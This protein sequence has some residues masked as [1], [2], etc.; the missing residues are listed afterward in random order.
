M[1]YWPSSET[2]L[3]TSFYSRKGKPAYM[4]ELYVELLKDYLMMY[5]TPRA[6]CRRGS[7]RRSSVSMV[8]QAT[9]CAPVDLLTCEV[10]RPSGCCS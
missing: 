10:P 9:C 1:S 8:K 5:S 6:V 7:S 4:R 2:V 3:A